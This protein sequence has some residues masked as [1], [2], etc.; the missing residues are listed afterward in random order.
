MARPDAD[1]EQEK[2]LDPEVD[3]LRG[4]LIRFMAINL[5]LLFLALMVV[6][7]AIVYKS[8]K[9]PPANPA[10]SG[11]VQTPAG[12]PASADI[13]LPVGAKVVS[14]SLSGDRLSIDAELA[15]GSRAI[16]VYDIAERRLIGRFAIR[17]K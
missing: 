10:L 5:G 6:I 8:R 7:A 17:N 9:A 3:K 14:Q 1:E 15:D 2:P 16:F 11:D 12:E 4:K 13:V